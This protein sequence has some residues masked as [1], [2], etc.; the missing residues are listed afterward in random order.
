MAVF[1]SIVPSQ[2]GACLGCTDDVIRGNGILGMGEGN[3]LDGGTAFFQMFHRLPNSPL[4]ISV[5]SLHEILLGDAQ[6]HSLHIV[7]QRL[8]VVGNR[9]IH[10]GRIV[11]IMAADTIHQNGTIGHIF[12][13]GSDLIQGRGKGHKAET[14]NPSIRRFKANYPAA[15]SGLSNRTSRIRSQR[16]DTLISCHSC[17][18]STAGSAGNSIEIPWIPGDIES[19]ILRR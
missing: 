16:G 19:G 9:H 17:S 8:S 18:G 5:H 2:I 3:L 4:N 13:Y 10:G 12:C 1:H 14:G 11:N 7:Y 6:L 15:S